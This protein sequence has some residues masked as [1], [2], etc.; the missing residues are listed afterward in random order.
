MLSFAAD[1][2][3]HVC[4][5]VVRSR[6][7]PCFFFSL[8]LCPPCVRRRFPFLSLLQSLTLAG[9]LA[10]RTDH[11]APPPAFSAPWH[12]RYHR[13]ASFHYRALRPLLVNTQ[14]QVVGAPDGGGAHASSSG[15]KCAKLW[16]RD[17]KNP[18][19]VYMEGVATFE[20]YPVPLD[21]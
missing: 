5:Q 2:C 17:K 14:V 21:V 12:L 11:G 20:P 4:M 19:I 10:G 7:N 8:G 16:I 9:W 6:V 13:L 15:K 18:A 1:G 3:V